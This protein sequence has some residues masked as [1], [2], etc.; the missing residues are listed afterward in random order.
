MKHVRIRVDTTMW[1]PTND[2][3]V[4]CHGYST[5]RKALEDRPSWMDQFTYLAQARVIEIVRERR[6]K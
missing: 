1:F 4:S 2:F 6:K 3:R 5:R